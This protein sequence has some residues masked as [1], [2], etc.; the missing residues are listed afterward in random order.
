MKHLRLLAIVTLLAFVSANSYGAWFQSWR[1][2]RQQRQMKKV[3]RKEQKVEHNKDCQN[4]PVGAPIDGGLLI[5]LGSAGAAYY[6][7][8]KK[9]KN[10][11]K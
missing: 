1:G 5:L 4:R 9:N 11:E 3:H 10:S 8:K 7:V 6:G 2:E